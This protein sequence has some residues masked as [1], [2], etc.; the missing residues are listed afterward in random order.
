MLLITIVFWGSQKPHILSCHLFLEFQIWSDKQVKTELGLENHKISRLCLL[1]HH[2]DIQPCPADC[3]DAGFRPSVMEVVVFPLSWPPLTSAANLFSDV[4]S[5]FPL[6][7]SLDSST[8]MVR[9]LRK[10]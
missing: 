10:S 7:L 5:Y 4:F 8:Q 9:G 6:F 3:W 2:C 1:K